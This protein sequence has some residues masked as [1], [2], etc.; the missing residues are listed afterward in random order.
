VGYQAPR[1]A[2]DYQAQTAKN[3]AKQA[4]LTVKIERHLEKLATKKGE[5][6]IVADI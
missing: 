3:T 4:E 1:I 6:L 5:A 2:A